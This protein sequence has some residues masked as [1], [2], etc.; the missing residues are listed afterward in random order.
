MFVEI[1][2]GFAGFGL[3]ST[4]P[5]QVNIQSAK[6]GLELRRPMVYSGGGSGYIPTAAELAT[7]DWAY[8]ASTGWRRTRNFPLNTRIKKLPLIP[9][10]TA[11]DMSTMASTPMPGNVTRPDYAKGKLVARLYVVPPIKSPASVQG[12]VPVAGQ[13]SIAP[14]AVQKPTPS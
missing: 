4:L 12:V 5:V 3:S 10:Q 6:P 14:V 7:G 11:T 9:G 13:S 2:G 1:S 8:G